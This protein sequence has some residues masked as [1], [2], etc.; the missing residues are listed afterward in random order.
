[1][2]SE[3]EEWW[4]WLRL[5][6][7][8]VEVVTVVFCEKLEKGLITT[9][10]GVFRQRQLLWRWW[11]RLE[12]ETEWKCLTR[13]WRV[14]ENN[15]CLDFTISARVTEDDNSFWWPVTWLSCHFILTWENKFCELTAGTD[16][17]LQLYGL[18]VTWQPWSGC[19]VLSAT[20]EEG[21]PATW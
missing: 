3:A 20:G 17:A 4:Q 15:S 10:F 11:E 19:W 13:D 5:K 7:L 18:P 9:T 1:M 2:I 21:L 8:R 6:T 12:T 16:G 14:F